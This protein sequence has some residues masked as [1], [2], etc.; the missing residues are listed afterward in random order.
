MGRWFEEMA[1]AQAPI[2][3]YG[4]PG[5][6][7]PSIR[8]VSTSR[9]RSFGAVI[10]RPVRAILINE[11]AD[12]NVEWP[13][14]STEVFLN[15][16]SLTLDGASEW[17]RIAVP[18]L[19]HEVLQWSHT[20]SRELSFTLQWSAIEALRRAGRAAMTNDMVASDPLLRGYLFSLKAM[21]LPVDRGRAPSRVTIMWPKVVLMTGAITSCNVTVTR[22]GRDGGIL[23]FD[24]DVSMVELRTTFLSR[25]NMLSEARSA[26]AAS[27]ESLIDLS[28]LQL[29]PG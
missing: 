3:P 1:Q 12:P 20:K 19:S 6:T 10:K 11:D 14:R 27:E 29:E 16:D 7:L 18:G 25:S 9:A 8:D 26:L 5:A 23:A 2:D 4:T 15:P 13:P 17:A 21:L 28:A 24:A 22:F